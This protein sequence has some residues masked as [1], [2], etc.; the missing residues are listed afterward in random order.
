MSIKLLRQPQAES[1]VHTV[2]DDLEAFLWVALYFVLNYVQS[3]QPSEKIKILIDQVFNQ[4][5]CFSGHRPM[6]GLNKTNLLCNFR[7]I[8]KNGRP[9]MDLHFSSKPLDDWIWDWIIAFADW[10]KKKSHEPCVE[11]T[12]GRRT[13]YYDDKKPKPVPNITHA[14]LLDITRTALAG[15]WPAVDDPA[16]DIHSMVSKKRAPEST[17]QGCD[18]D[19][20]SR[21]KRPKRS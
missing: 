6:G 8:T 1:H 11:T 19:D 5:L 7:F 21:R 3:N 4:S 20:A 17:D 10:H 9:N 16:K 15:E 2:Q 14:Q 12:T 13:R 18:D